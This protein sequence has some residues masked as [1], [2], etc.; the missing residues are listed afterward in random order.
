[1]HDNCKRINIKKTVYYIDENDGDKIAL[2]YITNADSSN[3]K[4]MG[5]VVLCH[6]ITY[7]SLAVFDIP[8][9]GFSFAERLAILGYDVFMPDYLGYGKSI[10]K[11]NVTV[12]TASAFRDLDISIKFIKNM[13]RYNN[14]YLIGWSWG[15]QI[16][17]KYAIEGEIR[18]DKLVLY[19]FKWHIDTKALSAI[20]GDWRKNDSD[21]LKSD[22]AVPGTIVTEVLEEYIKRALEL[23]PE[24]PNGPRK[25]LL[26]NNFFIEPG[27]IKAPTLIVHGHKDPGLDLIDSIEFFEKLNGVKF[28]SIIYGAHPIHLESNYWQLIYTI[29]N[30]FECKT[31]TDMQSN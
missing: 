26:K 20:K 4:E 19:G 1:M 3:K 22:F 14:L 12:D 27:K 17:G 13:H 9:E 25:E 10:F 7:S 16:A 5:A 8:I 15:A 28:Y 29:W 21:H 23:D 24:S 18:I 31:N 11:K 30:F 2:H 6:G